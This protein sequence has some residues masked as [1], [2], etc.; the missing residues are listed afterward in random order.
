MIS[1]DGVTIRF[2]AFVLFDRISFQVNQ[3]DRI[4]L[5]GRNGAG[6]TTILNLIDRKQDPDEG[7][8]VITSGT[9]VGYLPQQMKHKRGKT[10]YRETLDAFAEVIA[11]KKRI[12]AI[13]A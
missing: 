7:R 11:L 5:V 9:T 1:I 8:V 13:T 4:G 2:G 10:L 6:K 3:G 12:D